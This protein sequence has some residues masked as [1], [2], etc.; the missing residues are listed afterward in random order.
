[1]TTLAQLREQTRLRYGIAN[2]NYISDAELNLYLNYSLA[3]L[4]ELIVESNEDWKVIRLPFTITNTTDD[5]YVLPENFWKI[6]RVDRQVDSQNYYILN[7]VNIKDEN[8]YSPSTIAFNPNVSGY[9]DEVN[10]D[11][12]TVLRILPPSQK[13]GNYRI[14]YYPQF[15]D[16]TDN[17][18]IVMGPPGQKW[19]E[20]AILDVM[21][22]LCGKDGTDPSLY[23]TQKAA[24]ITR[25]KSAA[26]ARDIGQVEPPPQAG[27][28][29]YDQAGGLAN[30]GGFY[31]GRNGG[32]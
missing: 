30:G 22:K 10:K 2:Q 29:W 6:L 13:P 24:V 21:I 23:V 27:V 14:L 4:Y 18:T 8:L 15:E 9:I 7:R 32:W 25:I 1:M 19:I 26:A 17:D 16:Y 3:E 5:G 12:Y 31:G 28:K 11:G 20:Y